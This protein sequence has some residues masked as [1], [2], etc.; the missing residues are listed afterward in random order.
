LPHPLL[1]LDHDG[2]VRWRRE[3]RCDA[4]TPK[5]LREPAH[6]AGDGPTA[7]IPP[8]TIRLSASAMSQVRDERGHRRR[9]GRIPAAAARAQ[10]TP[11]MLDRS[12][13]G[14]DRPGLVAQRAER[15]GERIEVGAISAS[16]KPAY[17][18]RKYEQSVEHAVSSFGPRPGR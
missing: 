5:E 14:P 10:P 2:R 18:R 6:A 4:L 12:Q 1:E 9:I 17:G 7:E 8:S 15:L 3:R 13:V 16:S 11:E